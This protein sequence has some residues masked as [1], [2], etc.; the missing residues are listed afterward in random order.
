[1]I[2]WYGRKDLGTGILH[3]RTDGGDGNTGIVQ[4]VEANA[5]RSLALKGKPNNRIYVATVEK[6][7]KISRTLTGKVR[8]EEHKRNNAIG[9]KKAGEAKRDTTIYTFRHLDGRIETC[10]RHIFSKKYNLPT[11]N[12]GHLIRGAYR[13]SYGWTVTLSPDL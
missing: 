11:G 4:T 1:M 3:N 9:V 12:I 10:T 7:K 6:N 2:R 13:Q 5:K 8:T